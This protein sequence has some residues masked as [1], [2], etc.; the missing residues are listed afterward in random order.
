MPEPL[1]INADAGAP[2][3]SA[4]E[5][6]QAMALALMWD[7]RNMGAR[8]G[9]RHGGNQLQVSLA[10]STITVQPGVCCIDPGLSTPQGPYWVA[11]PAA[12]THAL[13]AADAT[14]PRKD[15][16]IARV[17]DHDEDSS[18]LRLARTEY[19]AG[20]ASP[21]PAEPGL[22]AGSIRLASIDVPRLGAGAPVVTDRRP[23]TVGPGGILPVLFDATLAPGVA[24]RYR[25]RLDNTRLERDTGSA[26]EVAA[27][28]DVFRDWTSFNPTWTANTP[29]V[30]G[31]GVLAGRYKKIGRTVHF[32]M[33]LFFGSTTTPGTGRWVFGGLPGTIDRAMSNVAL[34]GHCYDSNPVNQYPSVALMSVS[35]S[36]GILR[37]STRS[38]A[39]ALGTAEATFPFVWA[40]GDEL[41]LAGTYQSA[42]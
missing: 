28:P 5:L 17:Y 3:Y 23:Y 29:P 31:N 9:V 38:A 16:V 14:N 39:G 42:S 13:V 1:W 6:R 11:I 41:Y 27:D 12:E 18:G 30:L 26:W 35:G 36:A 4:N 37:V 22:P 33:K 8:S 40:S 32:V 19:L 24:G 34:Y 7:G 10:G 2:A 21:T 20:G 25:D 15:I